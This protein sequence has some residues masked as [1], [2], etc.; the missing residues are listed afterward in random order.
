METVRN[1]LEHIIKWFP[2]LEG[3]ESAEWEIRADGQ[4]KFTELPSPGTYTA[5][6]YIYLAQE[7]ANKYL[8]DY[9]R[10]EDT[11]EINFQ[12]LSSDLLDHEKWMYS[13]QFDHDFR[14]NKFIGKL[15]FN[16]NIVLF[17]GGN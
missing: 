16:G 14:P 1:D 2:K 9:D 5:S 6:G 11:P 7:T 17:T 13:W 10:K 12:S 3:V 15:W 4:G 8:E